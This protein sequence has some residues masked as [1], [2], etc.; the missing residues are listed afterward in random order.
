MAAKQEET[1]WFRYT[2]G[3][4][5]HSPKG[6]F[7]FRGINFEVDGPA[8]EVRGS[9]NIKKLDGMHDFEKLDAK[10]AAEAA[11]EAKKLADEAAARKAKRESLEAAQA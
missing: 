3:H 2:G 10:E 1:A 9:A 6:V 5:D 11:K 4:G 8:K 7:H